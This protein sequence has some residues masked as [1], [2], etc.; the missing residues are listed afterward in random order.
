MKKRKKSRSKKCCIT[1]ALD[2]SENDIMWDN[3]EAEE[4][5][6][7]SSDENESDSESEND[8]D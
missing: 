7:A 5:A 2:R 3:S 1:N 6:N 8:E 4:D